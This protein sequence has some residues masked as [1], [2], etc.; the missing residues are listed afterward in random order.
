MRCSRNHQPRCWRGR[1]RNSPQRLPS[2]AIYRV[3]MR[4]VRCTFA[5][6]MPSLLVMRDPSADAGLRDRDSGM[7]P[8]YWIDRLEGDADLDGVLHVESESFTN[9]W[10]REM[11]TWEL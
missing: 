1:L 9:P 5:G 6:L 4:S 2:R 3:P 10:T 7:P 8:R 11:Y